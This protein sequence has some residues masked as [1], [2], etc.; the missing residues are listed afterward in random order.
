MVVGGAVEQVK[1]ERS[2]S[3]PPA[4]TSLRS[5]CD[6]SHAESR[7]SSC[8]VCARRGGERWGPGCVRKWAL[9]P[10]VGW[11]TTQTGA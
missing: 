2:S 3:G 7:V 9:G 4:I 5:S 1:S 11:T 8:G 10:G 6:G